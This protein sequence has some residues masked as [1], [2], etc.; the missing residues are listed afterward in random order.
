MMPQDMDYITR[1]LAGARFIY[2]TLYPGVP[3]ELH[4]WWEKARVAVPAVQEQTASYGAD[5][6]A[7]SYI[8]RLPAGPAATAA[9]P[10]KRALVAIP[11]PRQ[12]A[13][14]GGEEVQWQQRPWHYRL[15]HRLSPLWAGQAKYL[16]ERR[17]P[18]PRPSPAQVSAAPSSRGV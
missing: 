10:G 18:G 11:S 13:H 12:L 6:P 17:P 15:M 2:E 3:V 7:L 9:Q 1:E 5:L 8:G 4:A 16:V 14:L